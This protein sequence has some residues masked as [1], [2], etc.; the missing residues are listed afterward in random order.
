MHPNAAAAWP[1]TKTGALYTHKVCF[2]LC[3]MH[4][5]RLRFSQRLSTFYCVIISL[6]RF[7]CANA[8]ASSVF[9]PNFPPAAFQMNM[10]QTLCKVFM[11][12]SICSQILQLQMNDYRYH[13]MF[14]TFVSVASGTHSHIFWSLSN[15]LCFLIEIE[16][17]IYVTFHL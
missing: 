3:G 11:F 16:I 9:T 4:S 14:T 6:E 15:C 5:E 8:P 17:H 10:M 12:F 1:V 7:V 13:Y 2:S